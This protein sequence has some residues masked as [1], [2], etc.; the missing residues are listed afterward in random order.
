MRTQELLG[1]KA[2][3]GDRALGKVWDFYISRT[4]P[5]IPGIVV[6]RSLLRPRPVQRG[7]FSF[8]GERYR[9]N[10]EAEGSSWKPTKASAARYSSV[11]RKEV[12]AGA[13]WRIGRLVSM[14]ID[15][16]EWQVAQLDVDVEHHLLLRDVGTYGKLSEQRNVYGFKHV[17]KNVVLF[18]PGKIVEEMKDSDKASFLTDSGDSKIPGLG[19]AISR[20]SFPSEGMTIDEGYAI[21]LPINGKKVENI[22]ITRVNQGV[23]QTEQGRK[24]VVREVFREYY[25]GKAAP[26]AT[27]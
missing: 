12:F 27:G 19:E 15:T 10:V 14:D 22:V 3:V 17:Y 6:G 18:K 7:L 5:Q 21:V 26:A 9:I 16:K 13:G 11:S 25:G 23:L 1:K 24:E 4:G 8:D 20:V 2:Y